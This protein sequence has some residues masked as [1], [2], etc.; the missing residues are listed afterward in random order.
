MKYCLS[1]QTQRLSSNDGA[2]EPSTCLFALLSPRVCVL[3]I[4]CT[5]SEPQIF[6]RSRL[7]THDSLT[8][9]NCPIHNSR[10]THEV[11]TIN[12]GIDSYRATTCLIVFLPILSHILATYFFFQC[13][14]IHKSLSVPFRP[15]SAIQL[16]TKLLLYFVSSP[17][18]NICG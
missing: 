18:M 9:Y 4:T 13:W 8:D 5:I 12:D 6:V 3:E 10:C 16:L 7:H 1:T 11:S 14:S 15:P 17:F 2:S